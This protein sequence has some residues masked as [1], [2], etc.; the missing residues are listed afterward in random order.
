MA[1]SSL[2]PAAASTDR[3]RPPPPPQAVGRFRLLLAGAASLP[4]SHTADP[5][6][7]GLHKATAPI[8]AAGGSPGWRGGIHSQ[9]SWRRI[10]GQH[11]H[12]RHLCTTPAAGFTARRRGSTGGRFD[13]RAHAVDL[14][15]ANV[16]LCFH[17]RSSAASFILC[18]LLHY[19]ASSPFLKDSIRH[20][21]LRAGKATTRED[22]T[23]ARRLLEAPLSFAWILS[24]L[25][26]IR[27][28][29]GETIGDSLTPSWS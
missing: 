3:G 4:C 5:R 28:V 21:S 16:C 2:S 15:P 20:D 9:W 23:A 26:S 27:D 10:Q 19:R 12:L 17:L 14:L 1:P 18:R 7:A 29:E 11:R 22:A 25:A 13:R 6:P 8:S 24:P